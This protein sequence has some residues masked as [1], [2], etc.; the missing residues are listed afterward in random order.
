MPL[1]P[2]EKVGPYE[3]LA[4]L[5]AGGMGEVYRARDSRLE[6]DVA[7]KVLPQSFASD[8]DR[9]RRFQQ[10][11][12]AVATLNHP[13]IVV[14]YEVGDHRD[15]YYIVSE[16]LEGETLRETLIGGALSQRRASEYASQIAEGLA[17]AH[18]KGIVHRDLKP[19]N[20]FITKDG[21][22]KILDFGLAKLADIDAPSAGEGATATIPVHTMPGMVL[23]TAGYMSP[24]QVRGKEVDAR[25]DIFAFGAILYEI[26]SGRR[27]FKDESSIETMNAILKD[28][29]PELEV[30]KLKLSPGMERIVR[31]CLEKEPSRR[32]QSA[33]DVGFALEAISGA[34]S[35]SAAKRQALPPERRWW[36]RIAALALLFLIAV[37]VAYFAGTRRA[38]A[39][40]VSYQ[41]LTFESGYAGPARFTR[42]GST[43][44]Y[45][46]AW[47]GGAR[48]LYTQRS[49]SIL[50]KPLDLDADVLGIADNGDLALI[51]KRRFLASWLQRG[52]LARM[53]IDGGAPR[54]ILEDVYD[55][56]ISRDGK[57]FAVVRRDGG[58]QRLEFPIGKALF[59]T[60]GWISD[61]RISP[62]GSE[63]AF[64][65]HPLA[66]DDRGD[67]AMVDRQGSVEHLTPY[68]STGRSLCWRP[69]GKEI[70]FT[71]SMEG[72]DSGLYAVTPA[73]EVHTVMRTPIEIVLEDISASGRVLF[74]S[75]RYQVEMGVKRSGE[76][77][78]HDLANF[79]DLGGISPDGQWLVYNDY[80][81]GDYLAMARKGDGAAPIRLGEGY[82]DGITWDGSLVPASRNNEPHKLYLYPTGVGEQ[83]VIDL[84]ELRAGFG[85]FENDV[86]F[87]RDGRWGLLSAFNTKD[88]VRDYL[89]DLRD[90][91]LRAVTPAGTHRG[92]LSPD[93]TQVVTWD[94]AQQ[95][96]VLI[97]VASGKVSDV[98]GIEKGEEMLAWNA[99]GRGIVVWNQ[100]LPANIT[101]VNLSTAKRQLVQTVE[102]LAMLGS[103]YTR[104]VASAD[105]KTAAYRHR[106]GLYA[107]HIA[108]G[109]R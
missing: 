109:L 78:A 9:L 6:R 37:A 17:A 61:V 81:T 96:Y 52:T 79:V 90:G 54:P 29:P 80:I 92:M 49:N 35:A 50:G 14:V 70:W 85:T 53:P 99:D 87:S 101:I 65:D 45:S 2:G 5:G 104:M 83:R 26:L 31:R 66:P 8:A 108:D 72:S 47:N 19:E 55:A 93:G 77:R 30:E 7:I 33:R 24:E 107:I 105:G 40:S 23:G 98:A 36:L 75:V 63:V 82:G 73:G 15:S 86:T 62:D 48:Q 67:V 4:A 25:T 59:Q 46:A 42:D 43:V 20:I 94:I 41:Q 27:A 60:D 21:R 44:V 39:S 12:R 58:K 28:D 100:E 97:D 34:S 38:P 32:F 71:A 51:L 64:I 74:E 13:N 1:S 16:L 18:D 88:E 11:A 22:V 84:G 89:V 57:D 10:E 76:S 91:K 106:R 102:P 103:M 3:I 95:K 69:D 68:Y 56:D